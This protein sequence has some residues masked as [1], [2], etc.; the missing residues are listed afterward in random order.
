MADAQGSF[1]DNGHTRKCTVLGKES[2]AAVCEGGAAVSAAAVSIRNENHANVFDGI[3]EIVVL[4]E[5]ALPVKRS[6]GNGTEIE[7]HFRL[8]FSLGARQ[9]ETSGIVLDMNIEQVFFAC[10]SDEI[11]VFWRGEG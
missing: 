11:F 6:C 9:R 2:A 5:L 8:Q 4:L 10:G 1:H 3:R 7:I